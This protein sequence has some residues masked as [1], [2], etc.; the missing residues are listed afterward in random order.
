LHRNSVENVESTVCQGEGFYK[1]TFGF[2]IK[3]VSKMRWAPYFNE[4]SDRGLHNAFIA[5]PESTLRLNA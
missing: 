5:T 2:Y 3:K 4:A 1:G